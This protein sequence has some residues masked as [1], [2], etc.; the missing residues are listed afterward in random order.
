MTS[1]QLSLQAPDRPQTRKAG[2]PAGPRA[3]YR[4]RLAANES[5][6]LA[7]GRLRHQVFAAEYGAITPGPDGVDRDGYDP[8]CDHLIV[9]HTEYPD[10]AGR[11]AVERPVATYRLLPPHANDLLPRAGGLYSHTEFD[12]TPLE[13]LLDRTVEAGRACVHPDHRTATP[14]SLLWGGIAR[15]LTL[16][17]YRYLV[18]C[19]SVSLADG[20]AD[21]AAFARLAATKHAAP[22]RLWCRPRVPFNHRAVVPAARPAIPALLKGYLRL[23]ATV[24]SEPALDT[25]FGTADFLVLL[26]LQ[27]A[28]PRYLRYFL[29]EV[30]M[31]Q[32]ASGPARSAGRRSA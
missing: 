12:L 32:P 22:E 24:C 18:G 28:D 27:Q 23:G 16:T 20:G 2:H 17:G 10:G 31:G 15:Y 9:W 26:D 19:A 21:A 8:F 3:D 25:D 5:E 14:I 29:G 7:A 1:T 13:A 6:V 30:G 11:A 4:L